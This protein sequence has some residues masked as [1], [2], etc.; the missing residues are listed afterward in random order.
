MKKSAFTLVELLVVIA[1]IFLL[2]AI[3]LPALRGARERAKIVVCISNLR[4]LGQAIHQYAR[5]YDDW[6]PGWW[7]SIT[8]NGNQNG[9][10]RTGSLYPYHKERRLY[11]CANDKRG[12]AKKPYSYT[13]AAMCQVWRTE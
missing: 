6:L 13:W 8:A 12:Y 5:E 3:L 7:H 4:Q 2:M 1:I 11:W 9:D 10:N